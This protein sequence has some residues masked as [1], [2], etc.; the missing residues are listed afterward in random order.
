ML[1]SVK[2]EDDIMIY[3]GQ[4]YREMGNTVKLA[5]LMCAST[6]GKWVGK[7]SEGLRDYT[8]AFLSLPRA[9]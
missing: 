6:L 7:A 2:E 4:G 9:G 8:G 3:L 5:L 1:C